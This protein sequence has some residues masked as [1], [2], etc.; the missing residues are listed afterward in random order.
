LKREYF[1]SRDVP[2]QLDY[3][4]TYLQPQIDPDGVLRDPYAERDRKLEDL[5]EE[6]AYVNALEPGRIL[7]V[8]CGLGFFLSGVDER[9]ERH[10][11]EVSKPCVEFASQFCT[12]FQGT[13]QEGNYE[14]ESFDVV[15]SMSVVEHIPDPI[16]TVRDMWR[17]L[18]PGGHLILRTPNFDSPVA[19]RF[20]E[21]YRL[22]QTPGHVTL[23]SDTSLRRLLE[24]I[25]FSIEHVAYP[26]F[27]TRH[28]SMENLERLLDTDQI[29]PPFYGNHMSFYA[30]KP[31][32]AKAIFWIRETSILLQDQNEE[33]ADKIEQASAL[34]SKCRNASQIL[35]LSGDET[36]TPLTSE[37]L[38]TAG[39]SLGSDG[40]A[41]L[42]IHRDMIV[43][44]SDTHGEITVPVESNQPLTAYFM[45]NT[46]LA[47]LSATR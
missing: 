26:Y 4:D 7:D 11:Q 33:V 37:A 34:L 40:D 6:V 44:K 25:G 15:V 22:L 45:L 38:S 42:S 47:C 32:A 16:P 41:G 8:G 46:I 30:T 13:V 10:G 27:E 28:F 1:V 20:G 31:V 2:V 12:A 17:V 9:W 36:L 3:D 18:K 43:I 39:I 24:D 29:S 23:F 21:N 19:R 14:D 5:V 35:T